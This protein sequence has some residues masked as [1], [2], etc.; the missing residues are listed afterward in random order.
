[1]G[2]MPRALVC[3]VVA[4]VL[5]AGCDKLKGKVGASGDAGAVAV[6]A[7]AGAAPVASSAAAGM[8]GD[9]PAWA[10]DKPSAKCTM[11]PAA[12]GKIGPL[13]KGD[14]AAALAD[15]PKLVAET[16]ADTCFPTRKSLAQ[17]LNDGGFKK[18]SAKDLESAKTFWRAALM[19]RPSMVIARYNY[20]C[21]LALTN[22]P[23][24]AVAQIAELARVAGEDPAAQNYLEKSKSDDDLKSVRSD[25]AFQ[26]ALSA[27]NATL[28]GPR[29]EP[30]TAAKAI[31]LLPEDYRKK[32][33]STDF[34]PSGVMTYKPAVQHFW[35]WRPGAST[36]LLVATI[37]DDPGHAGQPKGD[38]NFDYGAIAVF[39]REG[40][41]LTLL[42]AQKT[43]E[44]PPT[45]VGAGKGN[46]VT[47]AFDEACGGLTGTLSW[48][49]S[50]VVV[51]EKTCQD[52]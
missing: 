23:Q 11:S 26:K 43:G 39:R 18:Y 6:T 12:K 33:V 38:T 2:A 49:G 4:L 14:G 5:V 13:A 42:K 37:V 7:E 51:K 35:T 45:A 27:S 19:V 28:V 34:V 15:V 24:E 47:Y 40:D 17:A 48:N 1:M 16:G 10:P 9:V 25:P 22:K 46:T 41:K 50:G 30:E 44:S 32:K 20:A 8:V 52:L 36:E 29:K 3:G 21:A 31:A